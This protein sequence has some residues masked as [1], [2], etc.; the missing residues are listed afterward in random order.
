MADELFSSAATLARRIRDRKVGS[1]ELLDGYLGRVAAHNPSINAVV[2]LD[3]E[4]ARQAAR[5][6]DAAVAAG[7]PLGPLHGVPMTIK[8]SFNLA[9]TPTTYGLPAFRDNVA[10]GDAV[11]V[12]RLKAAGAVV[13]GKTNVP[14]GLADAQSA[15]EIYGRT[16]NPWNLDR[17]PGGSS[18]GSAA[19]LAAG[20]SGLELGSDIA[21]SL[22]NPAHFCG[23]FAHKPTYGLCS[24]VGHS[25]RT[26]HAAGDIS[27]IGPLARSAEDLE[28]AF[29]AVADFRHEAFPG[30]FRRPRERDL[31]SFRGLRIGVVLNDVYAEVDRA[32]EDQLARLADFLRGEGADVRVGWRPQLDSHRVHVVYELLMRAAISQD[33]PD[34]DIAAF[35][36]EKADPAAPK[37]QLRSMFLEG[38]TMS[39]REWLRLNEERHS[40]AAV[41]RD[42]FEECDILLCPVLATTAFPHDDRPPA[43]RTLTVNGRDVP[44][45]RQLFWAGYTGAY[46]LP[47]TVAPIGFSEEG[48]PVGVQI[49]GGQLDDVRCIR[50]ARLLEERYQAFVP[51]PA[52]SEPVGG[53]P[54]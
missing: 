54:A 30:Q 20:L 51:P 45:G 9:G 10:G 49:V 1:E 41:W 16:R 48:L 3:V 28:I 46:F 23:V 19:A 34:A 44:F 37:S 18:G 35:E 21:S 36:A 25:L 22:R 24:S 50:F 40:I 17:T 32:I 11:A 33:M 4:A 39:H 43:W 52:Y 7:A 26:R 42:F 38:V 5:A 8:E 27:V 31:H 15:N 2:V 13:F 29:R 47:S 14:P 53:N 12:S 6:A